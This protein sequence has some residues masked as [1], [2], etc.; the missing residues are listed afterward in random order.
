MKDLQSIVLAADDAISAAVET[1]QGEVEKIVAQSTVNL[2]ERL[3]KALVLTADGTVKRTRANSAVLAKVSDWFMEEMAANGFVTL[4]RSF[5]NAFPGQLVYFD[6]VLNLLAKQAGKKIEFNWS[7]H[8]KRTF[9]DFATHSAT[10][11]VDVVEHVA[12]TARAQILL[13]FGSVTYSQLVHTIAEKLQ[14]STERASEFADTSMMMWWREAAS[15]GFR[16]IE[17]FFPGKVAYQYAGP[18]S[19]DRVI[20]PWCKT[21]MTQTESGKSWTR[22]E[23]DQMDNGSSL[24]TPVFRVGGGHRCR[25]FWVLLVPDKDKPATN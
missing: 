3:R 7:S 6:D 20:R 24:G 25:H 23:I 19:T 11:L 17:H 1:F 8:D 9:T 18:P 22:Q 21:K 16:K 4:A 2:Q 14:I 13:S 5:V 10:G 15:R 12:K